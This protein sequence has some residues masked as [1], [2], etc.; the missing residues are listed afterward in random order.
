VGKRRNEKIIYVKRYLEKMRDFYHT[1]AKSS[2]YYICVMCVCVYASIK[3]FYLVI[4]TNINFISL[5]ILDYFS[6]IFLRFFF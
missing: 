1:N 3:K 6:L 4:Q 5:L 2:A